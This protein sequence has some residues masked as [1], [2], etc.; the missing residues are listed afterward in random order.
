MKAADSKANGPE[1][2]FRVPNS[3]DSP[4]VYQTTNYVDFDEFCNWY[5]IELDRR[6]QEKLKCVI[7]PGFNLF[8]HPA[9]LK[10][11]EGVEKGKRDNTCYTLALAYKSIGLSMEEAEQ[12][13]HKWNLKN[14]PALSF[15]QV[16]KK[17]KSAYKN[18]APLGPSARY[19][20]ELSGTPFS[21]QVW[22]PK[23]D[24]S[25]R[26]YSHYDEWEE[27][28]LSYLRQ[29]NGKVSGSQ[30]LIADQIT[31]TVNKNRKIPFSTFKVVLKRLIDSNKVVKLVEGKGRN[32]IT[33]LYL[34][35]EITKENE[36][37]M[38]PEDY[39][40][41]DSVV[42]VLNSYTPIAEVA[43]GDSSPLLGDLY[44]SD[45]P[46]VFSQVFIASDLSNYDYRSTA[47]RLVTNE[48]D[49]LAL[50]YKGVLS[51]KSYLRLVCSSLDIAI[52][53]KGKYLKES[54][55]SGLFYNYFIG[56]FRGLL[57][58]YRQNKIDSFVVSLEKWSIKD[59]Y[60]KRGELKKNLAISCTDSAILQSYIDELDLEIMIRLRQANFKYGHSPLVGFKAFLDSD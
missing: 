12:K 18:G 19:I 14:M 39:Q 34:Q 23:K 6:N 15:V 9:L 8:S 57:F 24:R 33:T 37:P 53:I 40:N 38:Q 59:L 11:L 22:E 28:V 49:S 5:S 2:Y 58:N 16:H 51:D 21:Y 25:E 35:V 52:H 43:G 32:A 60:K 44:S 17:V 10:L 4:V 54:I 1:R 26:K 50:S 13:L 31:S 30:R 7:K 27:D 55:A 42:N 56:T 20:S 48:F 45:I 47:W 29:R 3:E 46:S 41:E 36:A